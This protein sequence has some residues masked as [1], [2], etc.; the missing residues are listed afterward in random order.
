MASRVLSL[1]LSR[2]ISPPLCLCVKEALVPL[3]NQ[4]V[5]KKKL[6]HVCIQKVEGKKKYNINLLMLLALSE[7]FHFFCSISDRMS[8]FYEYD[9]GK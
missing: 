7:I 1:H 2:A 3:Y 6:C 4:K 8:G 9:T 5:A